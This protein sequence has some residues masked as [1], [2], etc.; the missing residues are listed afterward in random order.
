MAN[1]IV[2]L[3]RKLIVGSTTVESGTDGGVIFED[4]GVVQQDA[5]LHWD[6]TNKRL[7]LG[8]PTPT[9]KLEVDGNIKV[10]SNGE[11]RG[12]TTGSLNIYPRSSSGSGRVQLGLSET[13]LYQAIR[14]GA[15]NSYT[16]GSPSFRWSVGYL[17]ELNVNGNIL[18]SGDMLKMTGITTTERNTLTPEAGD[19]I[20][21][22]TDNK[23]QGYDGT[24]WN[25]LY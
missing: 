16:L 12:G 3:V 13:I 6:N 14:P 10:Q 24:S 18:V 9:E 11:I 23:H 5:D 4:G 20:Y 2:N 8:T 1:V 19:I 7:G 15:N 25:N 17:E 22:T 21:N